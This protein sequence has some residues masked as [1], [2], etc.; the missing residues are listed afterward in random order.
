MMDNKANEI[1]FISDL[2]NCVKNTD[3]LSDDDQLG[4]WRVVKYETADLP[5]GEKRLNQ[6][7]C[8]FITRFFRELRCALD[9][10]FGKNKIGI[11]LRCQFSISDAYL[12]GYDIE[13]LARENLIDA[14]ISY[15]QRMYEI[16]PQSVMDDDGKRINMKKYDDWVT[17]GD[18]SVFKC[19]DFDFS[20]P[21]KN[22]SGESIGP[23]S[24]EERIAEWNNIEKKYGVKVYFDILPRIM[25]D[26]EFVRRVS[27]LYRYGAKRISLWDY[28]GRLVIPNLGNVARKAG[29][30]EDFIN[31]TVKT[32]KPVYYRI[33]HI[34]KYSIK[35]FFPG[36][37]G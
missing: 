14:V 31:N 1:L 21:Y 27:E 37:G 22:C 2:K 11:H 34:G 5:I 17:S 32:E 29:Q 19:D 24:Q 8:S 6:V 36:W 18:R 20:P 23:L 10:K 28:N 3:V 13:T 12:V 15:P 35:R 33:L 7:R 25:T 4:K 26:K 30:I 9:K 16:I